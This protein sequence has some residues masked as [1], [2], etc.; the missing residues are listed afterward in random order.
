M[1]REMTPNE[2]EMFKD[3]AKLRSSLAADAEIKRLREA[4]SWALSELNGQGIPWKGD[5]IAAELR[6]RAGLE[7]K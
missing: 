5:E 2:I 3:I 6:R 4:I 7:E 1:I